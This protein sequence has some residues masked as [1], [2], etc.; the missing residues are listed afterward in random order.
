MVPVVQYRDVDGLVSADHLRARLDLPLSQPVLQ[1]PGRDLRRH[2]LFGN[3][4]LQ[5]SHLHAE[6]DSLHCTMADR[7]TLIRT[8]FSILNS[9][10]EIRTLTPCGHDYLRVACL[11]IPPRGR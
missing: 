5:D 8:G 10:R 2:P 1:N 7:F 9:Q 6:P 11:P 3:R 4:Y